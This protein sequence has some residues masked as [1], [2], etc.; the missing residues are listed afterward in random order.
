[1]T[2]S[3]GV[4]AQLQEINGSHLMLISKQI[5]EIGVFYKPGPRCMIYILDILELI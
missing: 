3:N 1:M 4:A 5:N 2:W